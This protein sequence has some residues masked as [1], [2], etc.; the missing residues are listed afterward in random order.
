[1][2]IYKYILE[3]LTGVFKVIVNNLF[4]ESS[5]RKKKKKLGFKNTH[6][7]LSILPYISLKYY[8]FINL[9]YYFPKSFLSMSKE[10]VK[11]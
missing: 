4:K 11:K 7:R 2:Y 8:F 10:N 5:Y 9:F 3:M 6:N 1:M